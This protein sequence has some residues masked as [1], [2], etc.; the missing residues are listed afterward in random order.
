MKCSNLLSL[1]ESRPLRHLKLRSRRAARRV[2]T[3][4]EAIVATSLP[5]K[6][7]VLEAVTGRSIVT[8]IA[9][10]NTSGTRKAI[11]S[12]TENES[13][14][15][16]RLLRRTRSAA[17]QR[18]LKKRLFKAILRPW[19]SKKCHPPRLLLQSKRLPMKSGSLVSSESTRS[20][21]NSNQ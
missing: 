14:P 7:T 13:T 16:R 17:A 11:R 21:I 9:I 8:V 5:R 15:R 2:L 10:G 18:S 6:D 3:L 12:T 19:R 4:T 20:S 1:L